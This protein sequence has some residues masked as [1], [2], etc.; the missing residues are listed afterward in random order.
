MALIFLIDILRYIFFEVLA[1]RRLYAQITFRS[2]RSFLN[3]CRYNSRYN[4]PRSLIGRNVKSL[5]KLVYFI[6]MINVVITFLM[7]VSLGKK[8]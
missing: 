5:Q 1:N 2:S 8:K 4:F 3:Y 7:F 6:K